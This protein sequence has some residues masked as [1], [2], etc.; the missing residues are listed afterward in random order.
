MLQ[1]PTNFYPENLAFDK[2]QVD[3]RLSFIFNGD[4]LSTVTFRIYNYNTGE[5]VGSARSNPATRSPLKY[6]G[7]TFS[8][9]WIPY[10]TNG[11]DYTIQLMLT[12]CDSTGANNIYDMPLLRGRVQE[13]VSST[14]IK[15]E[16]GINNIYEWG[17]DSNTQLYKPTIYDDYVAAGLIIRIG[18]E[19]KLIESYDKATGTIVVD[20]AFSDTIATDT[21][22]QIYSNYIITPQYFF[23]CR[24]VPTITPSISWLARGAKC[25]ATYSQSEGSL[26]KYAEFFLYRGGET[27]QDVYTLVDQSEKIFSQNLEWETGEDFTK[28]A[29]N[30][31]AWYKL[32]ARVVTQ[33]NMVAVAEVNSRTPAEATP[34]VPL[35]AQAVTS[36][37]SHSTLISFSTNIYF[38]R[39]YRQDLITG[40]SEFIGILLMP[41]TRI[42]DYTVSTR[43]KYKYRLVPFTWNNT[44]GVG[45]IYTSYESNSI[46]TDWIGYS[47]TAIYD[48]GRDLYNKP[49]YTAGDTWLF[50]ADIE[51][52]TVTQNGD[53]VLDVGYGRYSSVSSSDVDY[54]SGTLS[55]AI[56]SISCPDNTYTDD[57]Q[58]VNAWRKFITQHCSF[59]LR[60]QKG[61]VWVVNIVDNPTTEYQED[62]YSIP[63]RFSFSWAQCCDWS[64]IVVSEWSAERVSDFLI[65]RR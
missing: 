16:N 24:T 18:S 11:N 47:I 41:Q 4:I 36:G 48:S 32:R 44:T 1:Y 56:G 34:N 45:D 39:V 40:E 20:S 65:D 58:L 8:Y 23:M 28:K 59:I 38:Q 14:T 17:Y 19:E 35:S 52:T 21:R 49:Y 26:I 12:Q 6:N 55:G 7:E 46:E 63:T 27:E 5:M 9:N 43:G 15:I 25:S 53:R 33:D 37:F 62:V 60:S 57:I 50:V 30:E 22:Y 51:D 31:R 3:N 54:L 64:D 42:F 2:T 61:D 10:L 29:Y 13:Y